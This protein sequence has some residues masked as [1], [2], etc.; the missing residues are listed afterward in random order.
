MST[1]WTITFDCVDPASLAAFWCRA[2][3]YVERRAACRFRNLGRVAGERRRA[4]RGM[5]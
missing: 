4:A 1:A 3:G 2:L 5:G